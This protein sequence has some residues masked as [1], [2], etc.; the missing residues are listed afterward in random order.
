MET[1]YLGKLIC[2]CT[3]LSLCQLDSYCLDWSFK[4]GKVNILFITQA[5]DAHLTWI[6]SEET[7]YFY[8][9]HLHYL[10]GIF[11]LTFVLI[12]KPF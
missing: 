11:Q 3:L 8:E 10:M 2:D 6:L 9:Q 7:V 4:V 5:N 12:L 1:S